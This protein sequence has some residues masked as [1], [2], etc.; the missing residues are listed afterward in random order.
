M[1]VVVDDTYASDAFSPTDGRYTWQG[2]FEL[3]KG[4][5]RGAQTIS[6]C[7]GQTL[8]LTCDIGTINVI[9][10]AYGRIHGADV[11]PHSAVSN[12]DCHAAESVSIVSAACQGETSCEVQAQTASSATHAAA[13]T[14]T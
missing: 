5:S 9:D 3:N 12:Q 1:G 13:P 4:T 11:C 8:A 2:P 6:G 10:A 7:E 14:S